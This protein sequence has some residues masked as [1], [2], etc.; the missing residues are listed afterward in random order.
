M[1]DR[2]SELVLDALRRLADGSVKGSG[3]LMPVGLK[4]ESQSHTMRWVVRNGLAE[5]IG[6]RHFQISEKG[7]D[8][9]NRI[10]GKRLDCGQAK[11]IIKEMGL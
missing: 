11:E 6:T 5:R 3:V 1:T 7:L 8:I 10:K 4:K 9:A 2:L